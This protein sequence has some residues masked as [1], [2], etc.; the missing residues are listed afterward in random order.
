ML[1]TLFTPSPRGTR[2]I[3]P[4]DC[5][6]AMGR[7]RTLR[8]SRRSGPNASSNTFLPTQLAN[9]L[10]WTRGD[11]GITLNG[12]NVSAWAD[13]SG[14]GNHLVQGTALN[15]PLYVASDAAYGGKPSLTW[16]GSTSSMHTTRT[17]TLGPG[18]YIFAVKNTTASSYFAVF[19]ND[20]TDYLFA[21]TGL[22]SFVSRS[23]VSCTA[24]LGAAWGVNAS[25]RT[26]VRTFD[27]TVAGH[28]I[29]ANGVDLGAT[30]A[31]SPPGTGTTAQTLFVG[32]NHTP[33][34]FLTGSF[35]ECIVY[36]RALSVPELQQVEAYIRTRYGYY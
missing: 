6:Q 4:E 19:Q 15:Q 23:A 26:I 27:G 3:S 33:A 14:N 34:L 25:P 17:V 2:L 36:G 1:S 21:S 8:A 32:S 30:T 22:S 7:R 24:N 11:L 16:D 31:G 35:A 12:S 13:Q 9:L 10:L 5:V 29:R 28:T 20:S 18:T